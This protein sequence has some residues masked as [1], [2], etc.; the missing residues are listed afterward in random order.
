MDLQIKQL[1][2]TEWEVFNDRFDFH[3]RLENDEWS[4]TAFDVFKSDKDKAYLDSS[5]GEAETFE[6]VIRM[7]KDFNGSFGMPWRTD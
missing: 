7:C 3:I 4:I 5:L 2:A 6:E 1:S